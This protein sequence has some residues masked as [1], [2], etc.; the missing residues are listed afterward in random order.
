MYKKV[1]AFAPATVSNVSCG[2]DILG[3][4]LNEP[5]DDVVLELTDN[6]GKVV[7]TKIEGTDKLPF[8]AS[9]NTC[10]V[11]ATEFLKT[12]GVDKKHGI[13][14]EIYKKMPLGS[15]L[16]SSAASAIAVLA[17]LD[18]MFEDILDK[19]ELLKCAMAAEKVACGSGHADNAAP[20]LYGGFVLIRSYKPLDIVKLP[21]PEELYCIVAHPDVEILTCHARSLVPKQI[22]LETTV[23]QMGNLGGFVSS[24]YTKDYHMM[25]RSMQDLLAEPYRKKLIPHFDKVKDVAM[26]N[27]AI[28]C[29]ISGSGP[30]VFSLFYNAETL[31]HTAKEIQKVFTDNNIKC[32][33]YVSKINEEGPR[34]EAL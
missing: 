7:I 34:V 10:G 12:A 27:G 33:V 21:C 17:G 16:G 25:S 20:S 22:E 26:K 9:L 2:F 18:F 31:K 19:K 23:A 15:G 3:F 28:G 14:I 5:G 24:L 11:A 13:N 30:S 32:E 29:G 4:A 8:D 6:A 1:K